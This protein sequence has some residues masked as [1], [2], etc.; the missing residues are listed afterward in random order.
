[1]ELTQERVNLLLVILEDSDFW[2]CQNPDGEEYIQ[3]E[4]FSSQE[5]LFMCIRLYSKNQAISI[6]VQDPC[7]RWKSRKLLITCLV[8]PDSTTYSSF[9]QIFEKALENSHKP[10]EEHEGFY[11]PQRAFE[12]LRKKYITHN[13]VSY[14]HLTLPTIYSV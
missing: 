4:G 8:K 9:R 2:S 13:S 5:T 11:M 1:M 3:I 14:T 10:H 7:F 12:D 6:Q